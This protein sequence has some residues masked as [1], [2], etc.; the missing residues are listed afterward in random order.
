M[1]N[2][3][4]VS[5]FILAVFYLSFSVGATF[6]QHYCMGELVGTSL[7]SMQD[8][9]CEKCGMDKHTEA[10][11][12]CCR[13]VSITVKSNDS[14]TFSQAAYDVSSPLIVLPPVAFVSAGIIFRETSTENFYRAHS[15]PLLSE[16]LFLRYGNFRI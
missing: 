5:A 15:P 6:H 2:V 13:D 16:P 10:S 9:E 7:S 12:G 14:H 3:R 1:S 4:K 11:K 8:D